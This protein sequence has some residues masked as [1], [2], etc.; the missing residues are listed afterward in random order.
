MLIFFLACDEPGTSDSASPTPDEVS[1]VD[2]DG[3][4]ADQGDCD[5]ENADVFPD[6][7]EACN[8]G[9]DNCD[10]QVDEDVELVFYLDAD[11]DGFGHP[12]ESFAGCEAPLGY[13]ADASDCDDA[14]P[15]TYPG[16][17][18]T[19]LD[20]IDQ[21]CSGADRD[22]FDSGALYEGS[23][24]ISGD[25]DLTWFCEDYGRISGNLLVMNRSTPDLA[26]LECLCEVRG[27]FRVWYSEGMTSLSGLSSLASVQRLELIGD[28]TLISLAGLESLRQVDEIVLWDMASLAD[29]SA[30]ANVATPLVTLQLLELPSLTTLAGLEGI[31]STTILEVSNVP[32]LQDVDGLIGLTEVST[33][34]LANVPSLANLDGLANLASV[35]TLSID[36]A[37][38]LVSLGGMSSLS[39]LGD[40]SI[41]ACSSL[42]DVSPLAAIGDA[43]GSLVLTDNNQLADLSPLSS[44]TEADWLVLS[45]GGIYEIS[46]LAGLESVGALEL[47]LPLLT[48]VAPLSALESA[49]S[50]LLDNTSVLSLDGLGSLSR[51]GGLYLVENAVLADLSALSG[52]DITTIVVEDND[53]V[54]SLYGFEG[55]DGSG[56]TKVYVR[57]NDGL[58]SLS[59]LEGVE[60]LDTLELDNNE[61]LMDISALALLTEVDED[62][63]ITDNEALPTASAEALCLQVGRELADCEI[64]GN[65]N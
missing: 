1:D 49:N 33:L 59:G 60:S 4:S 54:V 45:G 19:R 16:A 36:G 15:T 50:I 5:D 27:G 12:V 58:L 3:F 62:F 44:L 55:V 22:C 8:G 14:D 18:D 29:I 7:P 30:L 51:L 61:S 6:A 11:G 24:T 21:D 46:A 31:P 39:L 42:V 23:V 34:Q 20:G 43:V 37:A 40:T 25:E 56:S 47:E 53:A 2:G 64:L 17:T 13:V 28:T 10:G 65:E 52:L 57:D 35:G 38:D 48:S 26:G 32:A 41:N 63:T 9:D